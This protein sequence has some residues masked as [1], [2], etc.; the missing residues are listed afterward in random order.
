[1]GSIRNKISLVVVLLVIILSVG[2]VVS[3]SPNLPENTATIEIATTS[4]S[5]A[6]T[7]TPEKIVKRVETPPKIEAETPKKDLTFPAERN[8]NLNSVA[9]LNCN[10]T[11]EQKGSG[12][13][14]FIS[15]DGYILTS[16]HL[17]DWEY[18]ERVYGPQEDV[19]ATAKLIDCEVRYLGFD[20]FVSPRDSSYPFFGL[21][22][23]QYDYKAGLV[24]L[25]DVNGLSDFENNFL[26]YAILKITSKNPG[27]YFEHESPPPFA[28]SPFLLLKDE[29]WPFLL[30]EKIAVPGFAVQASQSSE[31]VLTVKDSKIKV[32]IGGDSK[33]KDKIFLLET[34]SHPDAFGGRSGAPIF[35]RGYVIGVFQAKGLPSEE[36]TSYL[37]AYQTTFNAVLGTLK[38]DI[39]IFEEIINF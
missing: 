7:S 17:V 2:L 20:R 12:S 1:M 31:P 22:G 30:N 28:T 37:T 9:Y 13:G 11:K 32:V 16:R 24:S 14:V 29:N 25:P 18:L 6:A 15:E 23:A 8:I 27:K 21:T 38:S 35:W 34:E 10:F 36:S 19:D 33:F 3:D 5:V 39:N 26:D 4:E